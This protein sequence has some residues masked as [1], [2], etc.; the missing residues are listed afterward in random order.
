MELDI[1]FNL[2][3]KVNVKDYFE[4]VQ[5]FTETVN[6]IEIDWPNFSENLNIEFPDTYPQYIK[7]KFDEKFSNPT[8]KIKDLNIE[9]NG[10]KY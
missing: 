1:N 5:T 9:I 2:N 10:I 3:T 4:G 8:S 7:D 6:T